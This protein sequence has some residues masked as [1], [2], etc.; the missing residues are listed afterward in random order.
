MS[1]SD[2]NINHVF[3]KIYL[4]IQNNFHNHY[5]HYDHRLMRVT[6]D[7]SNSPVER[8]ASTEGG[9]ETMTVIHPYQTR[10]K[11][12]KKFV[13]TIVLKNVRPDLSDTQNH[14]EHLI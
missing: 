14:G 6:T 11:D 4:D 2:D 12:K 8:E 10:Q 9:D 7:S 1:G 3:E 13:L 5:H